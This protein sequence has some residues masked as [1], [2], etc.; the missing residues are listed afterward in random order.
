[1]K[2]TAYLTLLF[3]GLMLVISPVSAKM[4]K[5]TD[6]NGNTHYT[7]TPPPTEIKSENIEDDI[8]LSTGKL[9][10]ALPQTATKESTDA[11]E[12]AEQAGEESEQKHRKFC[13]QQEAALKQM[14]A[15]SL[16]KWKDEQG[17]RF[18]KAEEKQAK[19][20][21]IQKTID[22]MC[23]PDMFQRRDQ[24]AHDENIPALY[25]KKEQTAGSKAIPSSD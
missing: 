10:N 11:M 19:I 20:Q 9:G 5:W 17:E 16:I 13:Q 12:A 25:Q 3:T 14:K 21:S 23:N 8:R 2:R 4:Y 22:T 6:A 24:Y 18:L 15:N 7:Q 1:M